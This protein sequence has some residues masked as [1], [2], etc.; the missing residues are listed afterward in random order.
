MADGK[1]VKLGG[2][3][4]DVLVALIE[5]RGSV[6]SKDALMA[7][8]WPG[9][10]IEDNSL[11]SQISALRAAFRAERG[12]IRTVSGR[13][14]QFTGDIR[15]AP[16]TLREP[17]VAAATQP[18]EALP[19]TN[20]PEPVSELI[21]RDAEV[22]AI[23][24][25]IG[26]PRLVTLAGAGGIGK[27]QLALAVA[28]R[29]RPQFADGVWL[30]EF[31]P[32]ADANLI[33]A[34]VA[35]A[36]GLQ[37]GAGDISPQRVSQALVDR[38]LLLILDTCE[39]VIEAAATMAE[40]LLQ[41]G[42]GVRIIATSREPL[43]TEGEWVYTVQP[44]AVPP[45]GAA[46]GNDPLLYGAV[47]LFL[48]RARAAA[49]AQFA[50]ERDLRRITSI[51]RQ[52]DGIPLALELAAARVATLGVEGLVAGLED[53]FG[54]LTGGRRLAL[55]RHQT[56]RATFDWSY[57]LLTEPERVLLRRLA[58][59]ASGF[60]FRAAAVVAAGPDLAS[61]QVVDGLSSLVAKSLVTVEAGGGTS[62]YRLLDTTR[63]YALE[64]LVESG[65]RKALARRHAEYYRDVFE[66]AEVEWNKRPAAEW[67]ADYAPRIDNLRM[68]LDWAFSAE[69]DVAI[70]VALTAAAV[71]LWMHQSLMREC[72]GWVEQ[73]LAAFPS[74]A[75]LDP[76]SEMKLYAAL[77]A[78]LIFT[79]PAV[80]VIG[81]V[82]TKA[83]EIAESLGDDDYVL[84][85]LWALWSFRTSR[86]QQC[87]AL[88]LAQRF[89]SVAAQRF[90]PSDHLIGQQMIGISQHYLGDLTGARRHLE[91]VLAQDVAPAERL[92]IARFELDQWATGRVYLARILWLLGFP[93]QASHTAESG[94]AQARATDHAIS[95]GHAL[96]FGACPI[97]LFTGDLAA[98]D[99]Y[100]DMLL[101]HSTQHALARWRAVG[102]SH[103]AVL[104]IKRGDLSTGLRLLNAAFAD[105]GA[106]GSIPR[107]FA[108]LMA[109]SLGRAGQVAEGLAAIEEAIIR[110]E[111]GEER[112]ATAELL[113][114]KGELLLSRGASGAAASAECYF[115]QALDWA[116]RQGALSWELRAATSL[117]RLLRDQG[118]SADAKALL[119]PVYDRFT[120]GF[121]TTD[122][123]TAKA[124]LDS[125]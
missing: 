112:W 121:E 13:G 115:Q 104:V 18:A 64:R 92:Q 19:P 38:H 75:S 77:A 27:T 39:H 9:R 29:L 76:R 103:Q 3:A 73:A 116:R 34:T 82:A 62:R 84:R 106:A 24:G 12:L 20:I 61:W 97:A 91:H 30:T 51:C 110:S 71:P 100:V 90:D 8:V 15:G 120:E 68:A 69:G 17:D 89:H 63:A 105:P 125:L 33:P 58:V 14:Y 28:R 86:G 118:R 72:R 4:F 41:A 54:M 74:G 99:R 109:E 66:L 117:G 46:V 5:A 52:L 57:E 101:E 26:G 79:S 48:E 94:V 50:S 44:L 67:L 47:H 65:E 78:S 98:A 36:L 114:I 55:P 43:R 40:A 85:T 119:Q 87:L 56:L 83:L 6:V 45:E 23:Q 96:A 88:T 81:T 11:E 42:A 21:G 102:R 10:I 35:A 111:R 70:G 93:D 59:F 37:L 16:V 53:R 25:L 31:S 22:A 60:C 107:L 1:P 2:R 124:F 108:S 80:S 95:L 7:R 32:L 123:K 113:R 49:A 122:L